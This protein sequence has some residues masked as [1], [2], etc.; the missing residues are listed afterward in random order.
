MQPG[1]RV[2]VSGRSGVVKALRPGNSVDVQ[3][4]GEP[5]TT[6]HGAQHVIP[7]RENPGKR[8]GLT[9]SER[10]SLPDSAF[11]LPGRR[12]PINDRRHAVIAMQ[13]ILRGFVGQ[14]DGPHVLKAIYQKYPPSDRRNSEIW[15]FFEKHKAKLLRTKTAARRDKVVKAAANPKDDVYNFFQEHLRAQEQGVYESLVKKELGLPSKA[16][17]KDARGRRV[18]EKLSTDLKRRLLSQAIA[19]TVGQQQKHGYLI[20]GTREP[21]KKGIERAMQRLSERGH[22]E[23]NRQ[24]YERTLGAV[25]QSGHY[26]VV[27]EIQNGQKRFIVQPR[28]PEDL[29]KIPEYRLS[30]EKAREDANRAEAAFQRA[31][32]ALKARANPYYNTVYGSTVRSYDID[33]E[34]ASTTILRDDTFGSVAQRLG[35]SPA[36]LVYGQLQALEDGEWQVVRPLR[37]FQA[38][39]GRELVTP[40][41][42]NIRTPLRDLAAEVE[43]DELVDPALAGYRVVKTWDGGSMADAFERAHGTAAQKYPTKAARD[44]EAPS[45]AQR[46]ID[47]ELAKSAL[48]RELERL[49]ALD[50]RTV[51][52]KISTKALRAELESIKARPGWENYLR[53]QRHAQDVEQ[54][55]RQGKGGALPREAARQGIETAM[56]IFGRGVLGQAAEESDA[57]IMGKKLIERAESIEVE[58][59]ER[60][61]EVDAR[62]EEALKRPPQAPAAEPSRARATEAEKRRIAREEAEAVARAKEFAQLGQLEADEE[63][64]Y[65]VVKRF[66]ENEAGPILTYLAASNEL[67]PAKLAA[68]G[69]SLIGAGASDEAAFD[70]GKAEYDLFVLASRTLGDLEYLRRRLGMDPTPKPQRREMEER[71]AARQIEAVNFVAAMAPRRAELERAGK[72]YLEKRNMAGVR[73]GQ[74]IKAALT[75]ASEVDFERLGR[76]ILGETTLTPQA[77]RK[78]REEA[79][80]AAREFLAGYETTQ[81]LVDKLNAAERYL[82]PQAAAGAAATTR[83]EQPVD[84]NA[85]ILEN[86]ESKKEQVIEALN[87]FMPGRPGDI[88]QALSDGMLAEEYVIQHA[89]EGYTPEERAAHGAA[90]K[91]FRLRSPRG[92]GF[93]L[94]QTVLKRLGPGKVMVVVHPVPSRA[95]KGRFVFPRVYVVPYGFDPSSKDLIEKGVTAERSFLWNFIESKPDAKLDEHIFLFDNVAAARTFIQDRIDF[96]KGIGGRANLLIAKLLEGLLRTPAEDVGKFPPPYPSLETQEDWFE[97]DKERALLAKKEV[98]RRAVPSGQSLRS[99]E[100]ELTG[101][102]GAALSAATRRVITQQQRQLAVETAAAQL[103]QEAGPGPMTVSEQRRLRREAERMAEKTVSQMGMA[104]SAASAFAEDLK[105]APYSLL[106]TEIP[107]LR[108][109]SIREDRARQVR[110]QNLNK[111]R[112]RVLGR[113]KRPVLTPRER[114]A[115][116]KPGAERFDRAFYDVEFLYNPKTGEDEVR[117]VLYVPKVLQFITKVEKVMGMTVQSEPESYVRFRSQSPE[118]GPLASPS[119]DP[120]TYQKVSDEIKSAEEGLTL[121]RGKG[122]LTFMRALDRLKKARAEERRYKR[123]LMGAN[124]P[125]VPTGETIKIMGSRKV[126][127]F[128]DTSGEP[129]L[130]AAQIAE[131][132]EENK[133]Q[134]ALVTETEHMAGLAGMDDIDIGAAARADAEAAAAGDQKFLFDEIASQY[135]AEMKEAGEVAF[136]SKIVTA[137][138]GWVY[139]KSFRS[140]IRKAQVRDIASGRTFTSDDRK[141]YDKYYTTNP[142]LA[143]YTIMLWNT[144]ELFN[145]AIIDLEYPITWKGQTL[146]YIRTGDVWT[147]NPNMNPYKVYDELLAQGVRLRALLMAA[148]LTAESEQDWAEVGKMKVNLFGAKGDPGEPPILGYYD[149]VNRVIRGMEPLESAKEVFGDWGYTRNRINA[150]GYVDQLQS[151][152]ENLRDDESLSDAVRA[153]QEVRIA[154]FTAAKAKFNRLAQTKRFENTQLGMI[155][156]SELFTDLLF[157]QADS[158]EIRSAYEMAVA[159]VNEALNKRYEQ[160]RAEVDA[161]RGLPKEAQLQLQENLRTTIDLAEMLRTAAKV[162]PSGAS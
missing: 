155:M 46:R 149:A 21:T 145:G 20:P 159:T 103:A 22:A 6:R 134:R 8:G 118:R 48:D 63:A 104:L 31:P 141:R 27:A 83:I 144:P 100:R 55:T 7:V 58:L 96:Q 135:A 64:A 72:D 24:D 16:E 152:A 133:R 116:K 78:P 124:S 54:T 40:R 89:G 71:R 4:D 60:K 153:K 15:A 158:P 43:A 18:D 130:T 41:N 56:T 11:A 37:W 13:Y 154:E 143:Y 67:T 150:F 84:P 122:P 88:Y 32:K 121:A 127:L 2:T 142:V 120:M 126:G 77:D 42:L 69:R 94:L 105:S 65:A 139:D 30:E 10:E 80:T 132:D 117:Y 85:V 113:L 51:E 111:I 160:L 61:R 17:F 29:I 115:Q 25:R 107:N 82:S 137:N 128:V 76:N 119:V 86:E 39:K 110:G 74:L 146:N 95:F 12:F 147:D 38:K 81:G 52:R 99:L 44:L 53:A 23:E 109:E 70:A 73:S 136:T 123:A 92:S 57:F 125:Y 33:D 129:R 101:A 102:G 50:Q 3:F 9:P 87:Q 34:P 66:K 59:I 114:A 26:R 79:I 112:E 91:Q 45:I 162:G 90:L 140:E 151:I 106:M 35:V 93:R 108:Y 97:S 157:G 5:F 161:A 19:I 1:T 98:I 28:P 36:M 131:A 148:V 156:R 75:A 49:E 68:F 47:V 14:G 62:V 138:E